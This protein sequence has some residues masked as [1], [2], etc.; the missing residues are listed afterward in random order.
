MSTY[1]DEIRGAVSAATT[2]PCPPAGGRR[3]ETTKQASKQGKARQNEAAE[4]RTRLL[5]RSAAD[6][7]YADAAARRGGG[8]SVAAGLCSV[9]PAV[10]TISGVGSTTTSGLRAPSSASTVIARRSCPASTCTCHATDNIPTGR[11]SRQASMCAQAHAPTVPLQ[12]AGRS[13]LY[14]RPAQSISTSSACEHCSGAAAAAMSCG[15]TV[16]ES[17]RRA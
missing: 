16:C 14:Y 8:C 5:C 3:R 12:W 15:S 11:R 10:A 13:G 1:G 9:V 17:D 6:P 4:Q 2:A 7:H